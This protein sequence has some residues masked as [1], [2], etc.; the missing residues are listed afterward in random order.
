M[1]LVVMMM[2]ES[3]SEVTNSTWMPRR[4]RIFATKIAPVRATSSAVLLSIPQGMGR[5][6][7]QTATSSPATT[8]IAAPVPMW[9]GTHDA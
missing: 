8:M 7:V 4:T 9:A 5:R 2:E 6:I 3:E 1:P